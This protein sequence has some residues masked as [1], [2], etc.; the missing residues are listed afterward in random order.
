MK[1]GF[2]T[3]RPRG[4]SKWVISRILSTLTWSYPNYNPTY[5]RLTK[6]PGP[7]SRKPKTPTL[8]RTPKSLTLNPEE[9]KNLRLVLRLNL[10]CRVWGFRVQGSGV[11]GFR[12]LDFR[13]KVLGF[14]LQG[15][16]FRATPDTCAVPPAAHAGCEPAETTLHANSAGVWG[17]QGIYTNFKKP[18]TPGPHAR[19]GGAVRHSDPLF[20]ICVTI[21]TITEKCI[22]PR[23]GGQHVE[24]PKKNP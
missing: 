12:V 4:L 1:L 7:P 9:L 5:N 23:R 17:L 22:A 14:R 20:G 3:W 13:V 8:R 11:E 18:Q 6:S 10:Q 19:V 16:R 2:L 15:Q 21:C 24:P